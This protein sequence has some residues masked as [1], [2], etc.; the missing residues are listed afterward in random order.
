MLFRALT[1]SVITLL[2]VPIYAQ[3]VGEGGGGIVRA[4]N[5]DGLAVSVPSGWILDNRAMARQGIDMLFY[6]VKDGFKGFGPQS[7]VFAFVMPTYKGAPNVSVKG[8]VQMRD[9]QIHEGDTA[10]RTEWEQE[11]K[12]DA[13]S[14]STVSIV[15]Y[16]VPKLPR[17]ERVAYIEDDRTIYAVVLS[18]VSA[19]RLAQESS[20]IEHVIK[21]HRRLISGNAPPQ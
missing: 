9:E 18:A 6:P 15:K 8:L 10:A 5:G 1:A 17:F 20:F 12:L 19:D 2:A 14:G 21:V 11:A 13:S 3:P 7:P 4:L 16:S